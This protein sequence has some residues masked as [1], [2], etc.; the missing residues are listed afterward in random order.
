[1]FPHPDLYLHNFIFSGIAAL[2]KPSEK[3]KVGNSTG[4]T[5]REEMTLD[6]DNPLG[7]NFQ[8]KVTSDLGDYFSVPNLGHLKGARIL[9]HAEHPPY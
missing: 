7:Q 8:K 6:F 4:V 5:S 2:A 9:K 3:V 1:M